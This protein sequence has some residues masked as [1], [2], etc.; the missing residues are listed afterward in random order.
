MASSSKDKPYP[1]GGAIQHVARGLQ[2]GGRSRSRSRSRSRCRGQGVAPKHAPGGSKAHALARGTQGQDSASLDLMAFRNHVA[3]LF[4][5]NKCSGLEVQ[6][7]CQ[8]AQASGA[9]G[10]DDMA[11]TGAGGKH[12]KNISRDMLRQ[13]L[14]GTACPEVYWAQVPCQNP[15]TGEKKELVWMPF[16]LPFEILV[17]F[18]QSGEARMED[19]VAFEEGSGL[20]K[21]QQDFARK[22]QHIDPARL[23]ALGLHGDG[24]PHTKNDTIEVFTWNL[25]TL[26]RAERYLFSLVEKSYLCA[27]GCGGRCTFDAILKVKTW[28]MVALFMGKWPNERHDK[29]P[30]LKSD[31]ARAKRANQE[32]GFWGNLAQVRGDWAFYKAVFGF[33]GWASKAICWLCKANKDDIPFWD[34]GLD[35]LW[36]RCRYSPTEFLAEQHKQGVPP[37]PLLSCPGFTFL[38][39]AIDVLHAL[40]LGVTQDAIGNFFWAVLN[41]SFLTPKK[42]NRDE[43]TKLLFQKVKEYYKRSST[44]ATNCRLQGLTT[45]MIKSDKKSPKLR[46]KAAETRHLVPFAFELA[47]DFNESLKT[48]HSHAIACLFGYLL[49][50]YMTLDTQP[51]D[52]GMAASSCR[53]F[54]VLYVS[55]NKTFGPELW[56][57]KPKLHLFQEMAEYLSFDLGNPGDMWTYR[58]ESC[59]GYMSGI[60]ARR[61]GGRK[62]DTVPLKTIERYRALCR[63]GFD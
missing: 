35:A 49:R 7:L 60:A 21:R 23:V 54:C 1:R 10:V 28:V 45:E 40:D 44:P 18:V 46:A 38:C 36:R 4:L 53:K 20:A 50:F 30:W 9:Q 15:A 6:S 48:E 13:L 27:C 47:F 37:S 31:K 58:D 3:P 61:G 5:K 55:L 32:F 33:K 2:G 11:K 57:V 17:Q 34:V 19:F 26:P 22:H 59:M 12:P 51:F 63:D 39:I 56:R 62:A 8:S 16:L 25:P 52:A 43:K 29:K 41:S 42:I 24:V 14:R